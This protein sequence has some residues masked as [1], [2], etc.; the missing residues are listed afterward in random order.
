MEIKIENLEKLVEDADQILLT[1]E[2]EQVLVQL[3]D[4]QE[5]VETAIDEAKKR[6]ETAALAKNPNFKSIQA[7]KIKV[8]YRSYGSRYKI[9]E[10]LLQYIPQELYTTKTV[11]SANEK[12]IEEYTA[13]KGMPQ[14]I[15][16]PERPKQLS[17]SK[18]KSKE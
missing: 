5:Q 15:I 14:G 6:L 18:K 16:E 11:Y 12:A 8:F 17:F 3:L 2:A 9:D 1:P 7:D 13:K 4:I 10:S